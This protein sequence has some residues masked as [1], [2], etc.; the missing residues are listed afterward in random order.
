MT[1][2]IEDA[3]ITAHEYA[4][5]LNCALRANLWKTRDQ[6]F[7]QH[8]QCFFDFFTSDNQ[9][10]LE[11][12]KR[13]ALMIVDRVLSY[14]SKEMAISLKSDPKSIKRKTI[15]EECRQAMDPEALR[16][17]L[18][19]TSQ[20]IVQYCQ[21]METKFSSHQNNSTS[22]PITKPATP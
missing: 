15:D 11:H 14:L 6:L 8:R 12:R 10:H 17:M 2:D 22:H 21:E 18:D 3:A 1:I 5:R 7:L 4:H 19:S 20:N 9:Q 16:A 13:V